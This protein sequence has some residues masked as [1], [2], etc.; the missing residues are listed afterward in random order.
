[1]PKDLGIDW[2]LVEADY[3]RGTRLSEIQRLYSLNP[4]TLKSRMRRGGWVA[5]RMALI[6][7]TQTKATQRS[8]QTLTNRAS[9]YLERVVKQV[10]RGLDVLETQTPSSVKEVDAHFE[11]LGKI[12]RIA[13][14]A[15]GLTDQ[16]NSGN[17]GIINIA[18]LQQVAE[19]ASVKIC[20]DSHGDRENHWVMNPEP[21][22]ASSEDAGVSAPSEPLGNDTLLQVPAPLSES[23]ESSPP[24]P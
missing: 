19:P 10:D 24:A 6:E 12:D 21:L 16:S 23:V 15:L 5:K 17:K 11:A 9:G 7:A 3:L 8:V 18:V 22:P 1:M 20:Q 13:R 14:P 4:G 2:K